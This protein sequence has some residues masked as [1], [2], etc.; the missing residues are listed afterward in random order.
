MEMNKIIDELNKKNVA[1]KFGIDDTNLNPVEQDFLK[2]Y[3]PEKNLIVYGTLAPNCPNHS[4][5]EHIKGIWRKGHVRGKLDNGGWGAE[6]GF[7]GFKPSFQE[8]KDTI[9]VHVLCSD[10]LASNW[11]FLDEFEGNEYK[12]ILAKFELEN[13]EIGIGNIYALNEE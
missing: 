4:I 12:R 3:Q 11:T 8:P 6:L 7:L 13:G 1:Q 2:T 9:I 5:I 10:D